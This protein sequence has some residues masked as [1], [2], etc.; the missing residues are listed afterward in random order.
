MKSEIFIQNGE[1]EIPYKI[2][3]NDSDFFKSSIGFPMDPEE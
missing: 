2:F 3:N 1:N